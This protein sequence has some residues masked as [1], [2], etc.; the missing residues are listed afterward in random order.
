MAQASDD[1][2]RLVPIWMNSWPMV[3][4]VSPRVYEQLAHR[5]GAAA[6]QG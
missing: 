2:A 4:G 3:K 6:P 1:I 5:S